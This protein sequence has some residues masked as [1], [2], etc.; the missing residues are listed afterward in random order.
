MIDDVGA[1]PFAAFSPDK[2]VDLLRSILGES[3]ASLAADGKECVA[4]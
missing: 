1:P 3:G 4:V 2:R